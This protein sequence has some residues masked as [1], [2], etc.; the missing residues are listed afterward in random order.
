[1]HAALIAVLAIATGPEYQTN[2][3]PVEVTCGAQACGP[4]VAQSCASCAAPA[5]DGGVLG[6][7]RDWFGPMPQTC[8]T[9][10]FGCYPGNGRCMHRYPAFHGYYYRKPYNYRTAF[11]YPWYAAPHEPQAYGDCGCDPMMDPSMIP[12]NAQPIPV[13]PTPAP[14]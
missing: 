6:C 8:Y 11:D 12:S 2:A 10:R 1:M 3:M 14:R 7:L 13:E 5:K 9:P 4:M